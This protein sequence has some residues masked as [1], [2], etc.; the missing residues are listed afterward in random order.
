M[1]A[2]GNYSYLVEMMKPGLWVST[3]DNFLLQTGH[4]LSSEKGLESRLMNIA[5]ENGVPLREVESV[6]F[7]MEMTDNWS[8]PLHELMLRDVLESNTVDYVMQVQDLYD[9]WCAG[10]EA[11]LIEAMQD[12]TSE[13]TEEELALYEEYNKSISTDRNAGMLEVAKEYLESGETVFFAVGLAHLLVEDGL[14]FTLRDA[15]YTVELVT[16][17]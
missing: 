4:R 6:V 1:K 10:D 7:Q 8:Q 14:V 11:D 15:G 16:Y 5:E 17:G 2:S 9:R 12:D 3:L 13:M